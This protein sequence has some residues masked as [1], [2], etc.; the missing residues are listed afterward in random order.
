VL[1]TRSAVDLAPTPA[2]AKDGLELPSWFSYEVVAELRRSF[3]PRA[4]Q[5]F[6]VFFTGL[7]GSG[8]ST[9]S[10]V[11]LSKLLEIGARPVTLLDGD[12]VRKHLSSELGFTKKDRDL[13]ITRIGFVASEIT[14]NRGVAVCAPIAPYAAARRIV[15]EMIGQWELHQGVRRHSDRGVQPRPQGPLRGRAGLVKGSRA[16]TVTSGRR[17]SESQT[18]RGLRRKPRHPAPS[19]RFPERG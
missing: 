17:R 1:R 9:I 2:P 19:A 4:A 5:G 11:L 13:N 8:K 14:K 10:N 12:L 6:T 3:P 15:R 18:P 16:S 7:S